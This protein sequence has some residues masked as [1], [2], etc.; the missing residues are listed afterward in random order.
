[1]QW[2][3]GDVQPRTGIR[4]VGDTGRFMFAPAAQGQV[5]DAS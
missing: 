1:M 2:I 3:V 5:A 4:G